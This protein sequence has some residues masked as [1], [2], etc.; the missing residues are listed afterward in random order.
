MLADPDNEFGNLTWNN[1][2]KWLLSQLVPG[3]RVIYRGPTH[4]SH[5]GAERDTWEDRTGMRSVSK[6]PEY[7]GVYTL[8]EQADGWRSPRTGMKHQFLYLPDEKVYVGD[9]WG[10]GGHSQKRQK[11]VRFGCYDDEVLPI[12]MISWRILEHLLKDRNS[13]ADY[14]KFF[15]PA[16]HFWQ[17]K[18]AETAQEKPFVDLALTQCGVDLDNDSERARCERLVRWWKMKTTEHRVINDDDAKALRMISKAFRK[19]EDHDNDP[20]RLLFQR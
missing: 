9:S 15:L 18:K 7:G 5:G 13:R 3:V 10:Y 16:F 11:R 8:V 2:H 17:Q 20:E 1:Y 4:F 12:D 14:G 19:G 6:A